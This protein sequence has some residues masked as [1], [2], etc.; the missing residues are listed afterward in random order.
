[1][2]RYECSFALADL[3]F[4]PLMVSLPPSGAM[5]LS[6][7]C[8][9]T[10]PHR[11]WL[12]PMSWLVLSTATMIGSACSSIGKSRK[13]MAAAKVPETSI[14]YVALLNLRS[15]HRYLRLVGISMERALGKSSL[16]FQ[17]YIHLPCSIFSPLAVHSA[18]MFSSLQCMTI[19]SM[20]SN[21]NL[22]SSIS[23]T[24]RTLTLSITVG[25]APSGLPTLTGGPGSR[26]SSLPSLKLMASPMPMLSLPVSWSKVS[27][28]IWAPVIF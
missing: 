2:G 22:T 16:G 11:S 15:V 9:D 25:T 10:G 24:D 21:S 7:S 17:T 5:M 27:S 8:V 13:L 12:R 6:S 28:V 4:H 1:M 23:L 3:I 18:H 14:I 20:A 26:K 19:S